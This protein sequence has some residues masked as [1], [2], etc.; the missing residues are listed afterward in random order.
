MKDVVFPL[1][2]KHKNSPED[3]IATFTEHIAQQIAATI[4]NIGM[5]ELLVT[6]G[7]AYN[8]FL[9]SRIKSLLPDVKVT[10]PDDKTIQF[11]EAL[12]FALLG[13]LK[14]RGEVNALSSVTGALKDHS[15]G[16]VYL[17]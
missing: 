15:S 14:L 9:I 3:K 13:L 10:L 16:Y 6:G 5:G 17:P 2:E 8:K 1:M 12:I 7:G 11:K 4:Q